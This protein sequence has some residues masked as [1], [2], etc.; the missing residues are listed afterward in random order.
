MGSSVYVVCD[1]GANKT[2][3]CNGSFC[4][5]LHICPTKPWGIG[6]RSLFA[7]F[8]V[9]RG[10]CLFPLFYT[11]SWPSTDAVDEVSFISAAPWSLYL[12]S[13]HINIS[14]SLPSLNTHHKL[15]LPLSLSCS[16]KQLLAILDFFSFFWYTLTI[17]LLA[18]FLM[19][20]FPQSWFPFFFI[21]FFPILIL[22][23][24]SPTCSFCSSSQLHWHG[25]IRWYCLLHGAPVFQRDITVMDIEWNSN[26]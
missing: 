23:E 11:T 7:V 25:A 12:A 2:S 15:P 6:I 22:S 14:C 16:F 18:L 20:M 13:L 17:L 3:V 26:V 1:S 9:N 4:V 24:A 8:R 10:L 5:F 21:F 19:K